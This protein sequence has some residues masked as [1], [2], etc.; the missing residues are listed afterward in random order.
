MDKPIEVG[1]FC[2]I[3][4]SK[5]VHDGTIV[6]VIFY[7]HDD[8]KCPTWVIDHEFENP[9][10]IMTDRCYERFLR[11]IDGDNKELCTDWADVEFTTGWVPDGVK[12]TSCS[13]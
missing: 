10:G 2:E 3:I 9:D 4:G 8:G 6:Q 5:T 7:S 11:R 13:K 12:E 1:C